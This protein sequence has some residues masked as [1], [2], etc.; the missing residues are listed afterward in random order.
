MIK[1]VTT[2][3]LF[4]VLALLPA[5]SWAVSF[6][7]LQLTT[8]SFSVDIT[9]NLPPDAPQYPSYIFITNSTLSSDPGFVTGSYGVSAT[10][11]N[12]S[13]SQHAV[14][15][16]LGSQADGDYFYV[17]FQNNLVGGDALEGT[18]DG[19]WTN[20]AFDPNAV[21]SLNF[22]WGTDLITLESGELLG[23]AS[24]S[25][26]PDTGSTAALFGAGVAALAFARRR[27]G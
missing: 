15:M 8:K 24:L 20:T 26:V 2:S 4:L 11:L 12:F 6:S 21:T 23:S 9:G 25:A 18:L 13:G 16:T 5:S 3:M 14:E 22:Y 17:R 19:S 1:L 7:N 27:L 10:A